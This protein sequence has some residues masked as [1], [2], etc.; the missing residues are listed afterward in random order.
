MI[1][2]KA[3]PSGLEISRRIADC[4]EAAAPVDISST[5]GLVPFAG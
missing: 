5:S 3:V 4:L 2:Y 1:D